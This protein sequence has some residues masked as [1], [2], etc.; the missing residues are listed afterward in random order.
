MVK[1]EFGKIK[2]P[3]ELERLIRTDEPPAM[4]DAVHH[5]EHYAS[6]NIECIDWIAEMLDDKE[7]RGY[8]KGN[9]L[10]YLWRHEHKGKPKEDLEKCR[11]YLD[12]LIS[13]Q[14]D[15]R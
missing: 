8:L 15:A 9:M 10:K 7:F 13:L 12:K 6:G 2:Q 3:Y 1:T 11:W 5:P 14:E 4:Y